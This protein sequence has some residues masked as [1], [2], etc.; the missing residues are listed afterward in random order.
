MSKTLREESFDAVKGLVKSSLNRA[1]IGDYT[2]RVKVLAYEHPNIRN[3]AVYGTA[4]VILPVIVGELSGIAQAT[5]NN[6]IL[7]DPF[8]YTL[9]AKDDL[10]HQGHWAYPD[11]NVSQ[12]PHAFMIEV[13]HPYAP[14][15][16][17]VVGDRIDWGVGVDS[18]DVSGQVYGAG[19]KLIGNASQVSVELYLKPTYSD[20]LDW[21]TND[22]LITIPDPNNHN[23]TLTFIRAHFL[24]A[25]EDYLPVGAWGYFKEPI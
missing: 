9:V 19:N 8:N 14:N 10:L 11:N 16:S 20:H 15:L 21:I 5:L 17:S 1:T 2:D 24:R 12:F 6:G 3:A 22:K 23:A 25:M 7:N 13:P 18:V 4:A